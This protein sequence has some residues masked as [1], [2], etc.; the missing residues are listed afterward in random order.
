MGKL[1]NNLSP[2][3]FKNALNRF[4]GSSPWQHEHKITDDL[5]FWLTDGCEFVRK[6]ANARWLFDEILLNQPR[7]EIRNLRFQI[8]I[9]WFEKDN[10]EEEGCWVLRCDDF[11]ENTILVQMIVDRDFPINEITIWVIDGVAMLPGEY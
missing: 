2:V 4:N 7:P 10:D 8:W 1:Y 5:F 11:K 3:E 9:L 6:A